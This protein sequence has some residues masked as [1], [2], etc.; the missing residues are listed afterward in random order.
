MSLGF[1]AN[2][3]VP[4]RKA[5]PQPVSIEID[6][7]PNTLQYRGAVMD[8]FKSTIYGGLLLA[9][10][11][12]FLTYAVTK[13]FS[14]HDERVATI[15]IAAIGGLVC[16]SLTDATSAFNT[17]LG[18][19]LGLEI[20]LIEHVYKSAASAVTTRAEGWYYA[21]AWIILL[22]LIP[23]LL[24]SRGYFLNI[25]SYVGLVVNVI[26]IL[27]IMPA[28]GGQL[29]LLYGVSAGALITSTVNKTSLSYA[30]V[31]TNYARVIL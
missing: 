26:T 21:A 23:F 29:L 15:T 30:R 13:D 8:F 12:C 2:S 9:A 5:P 17:F 18:Y 14:L 10:S 25:L 19:Y 22:H 6:P 7:Q 11:Y 28:M 3:H 16:L 31:V 4:Q 20:Y 27:Y 1:I 24:M